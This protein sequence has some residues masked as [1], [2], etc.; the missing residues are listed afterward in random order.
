MRILLVAP[1]QVDNVG[2]FYFFPLG[3]A[4]ISAALKKA[5]FDVECLNLNHTGEPIDEVIRREIFSKDIDIVGT[6][7]LPGDYNKVKHI[8]A[9]AKQVKK[10]IISIAG[11]GLI[12]SEPELML[13][14]LSVDVA[15]LGEGE[16]TIV[17]L[18]RAIEND[19]D[20][21]NIKGIMY[22]DRS[23]NIVATP[24]RGVIENLDSL[25]FPDYDGFEIEKFLDY[26]RSS[27]DSFLY[28]FDKPRYI[29]MGA[30]RS[31]PFNCTFCYH[32]LGK[33]YRQRSLD[34]FF[35]E[36]RFCVKEYGINIVFLIDELFAMDERRLN[37]FCD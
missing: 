23:A 4:Y 15:V 13:K 2:D 30:S 18:V 37:E 24:P 36:V 21:K 33:K 31:C 35:E 22:K 10:N 7:C 29:P 11:G 12:T 26:Q 17:E 14:A 28:P 3:I 6:S 34:S 20:L 9:T 5:K 8:L 19:D 32:S 16:E 25:P 27:D 1:K